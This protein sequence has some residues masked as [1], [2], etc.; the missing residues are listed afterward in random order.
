LE[1]KDQ[2]VGPLGEK[3]DEE[4]LEQE[5]PLRTQKLSTL[6]HASKEVTLEYRH[7]TLFGSSSKSLPK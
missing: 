1:K 7:R 3:L 5:E 2:L 4:D 6:D